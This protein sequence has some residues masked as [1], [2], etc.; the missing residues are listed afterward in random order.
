MPSMPSN[1]PPRIES[2]S[3]P[4]KMPDAFYSCIVQIPPTA[5]GRE[6]EMGVGCV[7]SRNLILT[8]RRVVE[9]AQA[10]PT[11]LKEGL[12][13]EVRIPWDEERPP[14]QM[15]LIRCANGDSPADGL[16]LLESLE[17]LPSILTPAEFATMP[18]FTGKKFSAFAFPPQLPDG[19]TVSGRIL[20]IELNGDLLRHDSSSLGRFDGCSGSPM[21][22]PE[23]RAFVGLMSGT[24]RRIALSASLLCK[25]YPELGVKFKIPKSDIPVIKDYDKDDPNVELFG[26]VP[27]NGERRLTAT[28]EKKSDYYIVR[29]TYEC[30]PDSPPP[31][32]RYVTF[33]TYPDFEKDGYQLVE[34]LTKDGK[35]TT[36]FYPTVPD[37]TFAAIG[38]GGETRLTLDL[39][40]VGKIVELKGEFK[41]S[42]TGV[43]IATVQTNPEK[44]S[45]NTEATPQQPPVQTPIVSAGHTYLPPGYSS[46]YVGLGV[47]D[48]EIAD[49]LK[50]GDFAKR[51]AE[52]IA[53]R[54]TTLPLAVGLFGNWGTGKSYFMNLMDAHLKKVAGEG[55]KQWA[56]RAEEAGGAWKP[57]PQG[58]G[59]WYRQIVPVYF[60]AW[61]YVDSNL[62]ASL[63]TQIFE[64]LFKHLNQKKDELATVQEMLEQVS[65]AAARAAE[66]MV[67]AQREATKAQ[68][69]LS[70]AKAAREQQETVVEGLLQG[71]K[72]L[73]PDVRDA[74]SRKKA[75][76]A[77]GIEKELQT[78]DELQ[79]AVADAKT[80]WGAA[81]SFWHSF[82][83]IGWKWRLGW[84]AGVV[85][86]AY[87]GPML[88]KHYKLIEDASKLLNK[89]YAA[90]IPVVTLIIIS[91]GKASFALGKMQ[92]W[93][94]KAREAREQKL[95]DDPKVKAAEANAQV[96]KAREQVASIKLAEA[97][98][99]QKQ[100]QVEAANLSPERRIARFIEQRA[101][102]S[103]YRGQLGL[104]SLARR[105]FEELSNLFT[106]EKALKEKMDTLEEAEKAATKENNKPAAEAARVEADKIKKTFDSIDRIVLFVDDLDRCQ[107]EKV[108]EVLQAVHL[109]LAFPLFA[110]VVGVDQRCLRQSLKMQ[111]RGLLTPDLENGEKVVQ[112]SPDTIEE[113]PATAL[114]YLE[115]IFHIPF[116]L[117][118]MESTGFG[119]LIEKLTEPKNETASDESKEADPK[120][121]VDRTESTAPVSVTATIAKGK[122]SSLTVFEQ[123]TPRFV[124]A[125]S[126]GA[127]DIDIVPKAKTPELSPNETTAATVAPTEKPTS[128]GEKKRVGSAPLHRWERD[129]LKDYHALISTPRGATRFLNT[130]RLVRAGVLKDEWIQFC[131]DQK[132]TGEFRIAMLLLAAAA[133]CPSVVRNW[134]R[135]VRS[136][137]LNKLSSLPQPTDKD[138]G[139]LKQWEAFITIYDQ[140]LGQVKPTITQ[141]CLEMWL[142]RVER[143]T[144]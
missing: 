75:A 34:V 87:F 98:A 124:S 65:G 116:H 18:N 35:A 130:Y 47:H 74:E 64:S 10:F 112:S 132:V 4:R 143:F 93:E 84:L 83:G 101:Q 127:D 140:K 43:G 23:L 76:K 20:G 117:P 82:W 17:P 113:R 126:V 63:V 30:L 19:D 123:S 110:V 40:Q 37:F 69:E 71:L 1:E 104:V 38:D 89:I 102:S 42:S 21:W 52:Q 58:L 22:S 77:L 62:W 138:F 144:F 73:L 5:A 134:F 131:G 44:R 121:V 16:V 100:L 48:G 68:V 118:P 32:G 106:N 8:S 51:L 59:P 31:R 49:N 57:D 97:D 142:R 36:E 94:V 41:G 15:R 60:N 56:E 12:P 136:V 33:V 81:K 61:H 109:L 14:L 108:V 7:I 135:A 129:A 91:L 86:V 9:N 66:E 26:R 27:D 105:D 120:P 67:I 6:G 25:F 115:K 128:L 54:D 90:I 70:A 28:L 24:D 103:D 141:D 50:V 122:D 119:N 72:T 99:K 2:G 95:L 3:K 107:P 55:S 96:A 29:A 137:G 92:A 80:N 11:G 114:D 13:V 133:G 88:L 79:K 111:F 78:Y 53:S 139:S 39:E 46:E 125:L 85:A 45:P